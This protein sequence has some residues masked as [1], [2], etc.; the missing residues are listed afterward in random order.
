M[1]TGK[2]REDDRDRVDWPPGRP[3]PRGL[4]EIFFPFVFFDFFSS[5]E[6]GVLGVSVLE[7][8]EAEGQ[9][10][11]GASCKVQGHVNEAKKWWGKGVMVRTGTGWPGGTLVQVVRF[12][13]VR[14]SSLVEPA[15]DISVLRC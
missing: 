7:L 5:A 2:C 9:A 14:G 8:G 1:D 12:C 11:A 10:V 13:G 4:F 3:E 15:G 6:T